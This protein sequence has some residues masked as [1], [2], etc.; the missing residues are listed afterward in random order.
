MTL[1]NQPKEVFMEFISKLTLTFFLI[2]LSIPSFTQEE[3]IISVYEGSSIIF[4]DKI[5]Y[6]EMPVVMNDTTVEVVEGI[7]RRLWCKAPEGRSPLEIIRNYENAIRAREG[8]ILF[9]TREPKAVEIEDRKLGDYFKNNRKDR[10]LAPKVFSYHHFP[11]EM[12]EYMTA[13][14]STPNSDVYILIGAGEGHWAAQEKGLVYFEL[15]TLE[16]E[17]MELGMVTI[18][19]MKEG[20][21][22]KG[23]IAVYDIYFE[24]G[25]STVRQKSS[26]ALEVI[27]TFLK[28][29][30]ETKF[31]VVGHTDNVGQYDMN[32][33]L[34]EARAHAVVE[35]LVNE[36]S[37]DPDQLKPVGVGPVSPVFNNETEEGKAKNRRVEIVKR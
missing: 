17:P 27:S 28:G 10:G 11:V 33:E 21:A 31:L 26:E 7:L 25:E 34:S 15:I 3:E 4:D 6:A 16:T 1:I 29:R 32:V 2:C 37:I 19:A 24:T 22:E 12:S 8:E 30:P 13:R 9:I 36:Y 20:I 14:I 5:G 35:K 23:R 18:D